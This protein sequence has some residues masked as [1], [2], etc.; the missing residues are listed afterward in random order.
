MGSSC[1]LPQ[2]RGGKVQ[3]HKP[4]KAGERLVGM[5][6]AGMEGGYVPSQGTMAGVGFFSPIFVLGIQEF[7]A[8][9]AGIPG[10]TL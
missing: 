10:A 5:W 6:R 2:L 1:L 4:D 9:G 3:G 7:D 8:S